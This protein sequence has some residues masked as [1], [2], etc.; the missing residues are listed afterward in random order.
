MFSFGHHVKMRV[1]EMLYFKSFY[2]FPPSV[3]VFNCQFLDS[4]K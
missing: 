2:D 1:P 3:V 4:G